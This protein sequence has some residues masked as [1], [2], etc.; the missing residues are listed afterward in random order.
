[1]SFI[2]LAADRVQVGLGVAVP[3]HF[4][5]VIEHVPFPSVVRDDG[6][7]LKHAGARHALPLQ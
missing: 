5:A 2:F 7:W 1:M 4:G 3:E 6:N